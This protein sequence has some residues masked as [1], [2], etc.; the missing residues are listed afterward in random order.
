MAVTPKG[1]YYPS[2][3]SAQADLL[4]DLEDMAESI[5]TALDNV[6]IPVDSA[7]SPTSE[8]PVQNKVIT[9]NI[10]DLEAENAELKNIIDQIV[11][12][13]TQ[14]GTD[15]TLQNT[16]DA[17]LKNLTPKGNT[18]QETYNGDNLVNYDGTQINLVKSTARTISITPTNFPLTLPAGTYTIALPDL[19]MTNNSYNFAIQLFIT[20]GTYIATG[21][22]NSVKSYTFTLSEEK[23]FTKLY[24]FVS[25][26]DNDN[27]T[28]TFSKIML[29]TGNTAKEWEKFVGGTASPNPDFP[30]NVK[31]VTGNNNVVISNKNLVT[32][33]QRASNI[34]Y[35]NGTTSS[36]DFIFA[37]R[38]IRII[39]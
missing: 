9:A 23:T 27:A 18:S 12:T 11:P 15:I 28:A 24:C 13:T 7:L 17:K 38:N 6:V 19:V 10:E 5:D 16:L 34:L 33:T 22:N 35:F 36:G 39:L 1:I 32:S 8:N 2:T 30:Q 3:P 25:N 37:P 29:N 21:Y 14:E 4:T 26:S 31:V 20:G